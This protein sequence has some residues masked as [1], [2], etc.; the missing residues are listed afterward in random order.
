MSTSEAAP[1][2][3]SAPS[4]VAVARA[5]GLAGKERLP[6]LDLLRVVAS[7]LIVWHHL[8]FYGPLSDVAYPL[9][10]A[11][12]EWLFEYARMAVQVFFVVG[13]FVSARG[14]DR[15]LP[16]SP[17]H[18]ARQLG[19]RYL[20]L[21]VPYLAT[22]ALAVVANEVARGWM[23]HASISSRPTVGQLL[24]HA[25][26][27]HDLLGYEALTAG[28]WYLAIDFQLTAL[29]LAMAAVASALCRSR[30]TRTLGVVQAALGAL[31]LASLFWFNRD[32]RFDAWALYFLG[33][34]YLGMAL[35]WTLDERLPR[36]AL[37]AY[38]ALVAVA[39][40]VDFRPRLWVALGAAAL[41]L[42]SAYWPGL[43]RWADR[44]LI[45]YLGALSYA[46]FLVHF[47]VCLVANA[48]FSRSVGASAHLA[49]GGMLVAYA[50]S[51]LA[52]TLFHRAIEGRLQPSGRPLR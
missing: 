23:D 12:L 30:P 33:S 46:L 39:V 27:L 6:F 42:L 5:S 26:F 38:A 20:R 50:A 35:H 52:A 28:I 9:T 37:A 19:R 18:A 16:L 24:A 21:G 41:I 7:H 25:T 2:S 40:G 17:A 22:L 45:R 13:G 36:W 1:P 4:P 29:V 10:P 14:V 32:P 34:Y 48:W 15:L 44:R 49:W 3:K 43:G 11:L 8:A 31:A 47:P 51:L